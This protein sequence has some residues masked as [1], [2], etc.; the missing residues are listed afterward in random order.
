MGISCVPMGEIEESLRLWVENV[1]WSLDDGDRLV[2][3]LD[4]VNSALSIRDNSNELQSKIGWVHIDQ[5]LVW[6][7]LL[8]ASWDED[9]R[10]VGSQVA[11]NGSPWLSAGWECLQ[12]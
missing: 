8:A 11:R 6:N 2:E 12:G 9:I 7:A 1:G 5:E 4:L 10:L 3:S